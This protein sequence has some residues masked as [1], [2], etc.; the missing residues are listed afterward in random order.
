M[1]NDLSQLWIVWEIPST[2]RYISFGSVALKKTC[3]E[4]GNFQD[5]FEI[6]LLKGLHKILQ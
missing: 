3:I 2:K 4:L 1:N 5:R 6:N